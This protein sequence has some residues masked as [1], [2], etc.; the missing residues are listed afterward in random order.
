MPFRQLSDSCET[1]NGKMN[2]EGGWVSL[3]N[4]FKRNRGVLC[5]PISLISDSRFLTCAI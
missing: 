5:T 2:L 4:G 1:V 3:F